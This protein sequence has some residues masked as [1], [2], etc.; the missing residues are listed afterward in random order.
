MEHFSLIYD[1]CRAALAGDIALAR[2]STKRLRDAIAAGGDVED[3]ELLARLIKASG[4]KSKGPI[5][6]F[7]QAETPAALDVCN[8]ILTRQALISRK[9]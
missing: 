4:K 1:V 8:E 6:H 5:V 2:Q 9:R 3:A 7:V